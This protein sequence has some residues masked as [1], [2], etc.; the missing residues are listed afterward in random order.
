[1]SW[2][3]TSKLILCDESVTDP[4]PLHCAVAD[5]LGDRAAG[6]HFRLC[7]G[8]TPWHIA[9]SGANMFDKSNAVIPTN[10]KLDKHLSTSFLLYLY[11]HT[12]VSKPLQSSPRTYPHLLQSSQEHSARTFETCLPQG[13][14]L[15]TISAHTW[16]QWASQRTW[17]SKTTHIRFGVW[18]QA[19]N[20]L[21]KKKSWPH[22]KMVKQWPAYGNYCGNLC[23]SATLGHATMVNTPPSCEAWTGLGMPWWIGYSFCAKFNKRKLVLTL[24]CDQP[25][26]A[27]NIGTTTKTGVSPRGCGWNWQTAAC[28]KPCLDKVPRQPSG[29]LRRGQH[30]LPASTVL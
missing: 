22:K 3:S 5:N 8:P 11:L 30:P 15:Q 4:T 9:G 25:F 21:R 29:C 14:Q 24:K 10:V 12:P 2:T 26:I 28:T 27:R 7:P 23:V 18:M 13:S 6:S 17:S 16:K 19:P 20:V 1:M